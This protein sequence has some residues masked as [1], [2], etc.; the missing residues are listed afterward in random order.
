[1]LI[2]SVLLAFA[3]V[4]WMRWRRG[5][6]R[7]ALMA[8]EDRAFMELCRRLRL[9]REAQ[10]EL[11]RMGAASGLHPVALLA[12][13]SSLQGALDRFGGAAGPSRAGVVKELR[14][15]ARPA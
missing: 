10:Q 12:S 6:R 9:S 7:A 2:A 8:P 15:L 1:M 5:Q 14:S 11:R 13:P 4:G 3:A